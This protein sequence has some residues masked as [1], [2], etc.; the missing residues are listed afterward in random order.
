MQETALCSAV[1]GG[2]GS[3]EW[4]VVGMSS[5]TVLIIRDLKVERVVKAHKAPMY[6]ILVTNEVS[7][8][9]KY[10]NTCICR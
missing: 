7:S 2:E 10:L 8:V 4:W 5:G 6:A 9:D 1:G 3:E